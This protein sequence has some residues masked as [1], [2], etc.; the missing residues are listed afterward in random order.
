MNISD[1]NKKESSV[2]IFHDKL[3]TLFDFAE[4]KLETKPPGRFRKIANFFRREI[5]S[6][7]IA[8]TIAKYC[9]QNHDNLLTL[10][11]DR[12]IEIVNKLKNR[13]IE[14]HKKSPKSITKQF[15]NYIK[16][17]DRSEPGRDEKDKHIL[18]L[19]RRKHK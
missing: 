9:N 19:F 14:I 6:D 11:K 3:N 17:I 10:D 8:S 18:N 5:P 16:L 15:D 1:Y 4:K 12:A 7:K 2:N 13:Q